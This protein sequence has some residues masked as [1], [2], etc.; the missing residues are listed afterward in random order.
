MCWAVS[1]ILN[2]KIFYGCLPV[3]GLVPYECWSHRQYPSGTSKIEKGQTHSTVRAFPPRA[4]SGLQNNWTR[5]HPLVVY[6]KK[7]W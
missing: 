1:K 3:L 2:H 5:R 7:L 6:H 4:G